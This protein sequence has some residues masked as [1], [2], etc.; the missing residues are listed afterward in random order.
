MEEEV[1]L[2]Q[3]QLVDVK[4]RADNLTAQLQAA[5]EKIKSTDELKM[6]L[7]AAIEKI[8][9]LELSRSALEGQEKDMAVE[10]EQLKQDL[11]SAQD[12]KKKAQ[13]D[14]AEENEAGFDR[15]IS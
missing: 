4:D 5:N 1:G 6:N 10:V 15:A 2:L 7:Q 3:Q 13:E 9:Q 11:V 8:T 14:A 12:E